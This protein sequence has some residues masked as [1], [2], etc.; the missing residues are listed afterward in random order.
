MNGTHMVLR[1]YTLKHI[2]NG[3]IRASFALENP[4]PGDVYQLDGMAVTPDG[5]WHTCGLAGGQAPWQLETCEYK[6]DRKQA[7]ISFRLQWLCDDRDPFH[8]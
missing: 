3:A 4:G 1:R 7:E 8:P 6:L 5:D 2:D